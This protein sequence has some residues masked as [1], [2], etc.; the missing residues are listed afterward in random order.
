MHSFR[1]SLIY[2][3]IN[4]AVPFQGPSSWRKPPAARG[5]KHIRLAKELAQRWFSG[6]MPEVSDTEC[7]YIAWSQK[8]HSAIWKQ[9][10]YE[11]EAAES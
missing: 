4:L 1:Q 3:L 8:V 5:G 11:V 2:S 6:N 7:A 10:Q 9:V